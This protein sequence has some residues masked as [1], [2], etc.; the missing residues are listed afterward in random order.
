MNHSIAF[1]KGWADQKGM[2]DNILEMVMFKCILF[3]I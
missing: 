1:I 3:A 2:D